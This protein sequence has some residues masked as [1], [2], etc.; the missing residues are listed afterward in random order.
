MNGVIRFG[1]FVSVVALIAV[2]VYANTLRGEIARRDASI[3][4]LTSDRDSLKT[5]SD[6][7][8]AKVPENGK[9]LEQAQSQIHD[10]Q[11]QLEEA[12]KP[13]PGRARRR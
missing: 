11:A 3:A 2:G 13:A 5:K 9:A 4:A 8:Q 1:F 6:Q 7:Q 10:L 12:K